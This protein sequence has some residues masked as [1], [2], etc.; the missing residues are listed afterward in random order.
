[1][2]EREFKGLETEICGYMYEA[3]KSMEE[4]QQTND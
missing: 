4:L 2:Q 3:E 1:M